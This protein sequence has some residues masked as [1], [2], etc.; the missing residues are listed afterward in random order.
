MILDIKKFPNPVLRLKAVEVTNIDESILTLMNN[1]VETM[2]HAPGVGLAAPQVGVS[3]RI[4]VVDLAANQQE[5]DIQ[6]FIN[7]QI[8]EFEGNESGEEGCLSLPGEFALVK[9]ASKILLKALNDKG[10]ELKL[11]LEGL[12]ARIVQHEIDHLDG[13]LFVDRL[14]IFKREAI[15]KHIKKRFA[16]GEY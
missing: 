7:P 14:S 11:E 9:R 16:A 2:T 4:I 6:K 1:M 15:K 10:N 8:I 13:I 3:Q 5:A 12:P